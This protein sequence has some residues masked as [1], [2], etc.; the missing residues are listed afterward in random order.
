[1][2]A[3][4]CLG[5][6]LLVVALFPGCSEPSGAKV[7]IAVQVETAEGKKVQIAEQKQEIS[8]EQALK[9]AEEDAAKAYRDLGVY[10]V[11]ATLVDDNWKVDY[12]LKDPNSVGGGPHYLISRT[13]G[14]IVS[15]RYEQ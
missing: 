12:R 15:R 5:Q 1:M 9:I 8:K 11:S 7:D 3:L 4:M 14:K 10:E 2:K 6:L 13:A